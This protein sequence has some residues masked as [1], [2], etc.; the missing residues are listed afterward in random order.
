[1]DKADSLAIERPA[2]SIRAAFFIVGAA[3]GALLVAVAWLFYP[4][5]KSTKVHVLDAP[6]VLSAD[7]TS[8]H[9]HLLPKGTT[10][11]YDQGFAEGFTRYRVYVNI[12]RTPL[13]LQELDD[14]TMVAPLEARM[15]E[16]E[17]LKGAPH[18]P[19]LTR[20]ELEAILASGSMTRDEIK[21]VFDAA[22][23]RRK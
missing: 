22:M 6:M 19:V 2:R 17:D 11:Y 8:A 20:Q 12:D 4:L 18:R 16:G 9:V 21:A 14:P 23:R 1:M 7:T 15:M 3:A 13:A 5:Y 10:L